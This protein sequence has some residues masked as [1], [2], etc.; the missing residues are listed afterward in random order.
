MYLQTIWSKVGRVNTFAAN[1]DYTRGNHRN[2]FFI[3]KVKFEA[4][5]DVLKTNRCVY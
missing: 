2:L 4:F 1:Y 5:A 3:K